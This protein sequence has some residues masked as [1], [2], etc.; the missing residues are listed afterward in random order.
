M[1]RRRDAGGGKAQDVQELPDSDKPVQP[2][3]HERSGEGLLPKQVEGDN[4]REGKPVEAH[5][6]LGVRPAQPGEHRAG[7]RPLIRRSSGMTIGLEHGFELGGGDRLAHEVALHLVTAEAA[8][9]GEL[10]GRL[11][12]FGH[13]LHAEAVGKADDGIDD[14]GAS[15]L[16]RWQD[17]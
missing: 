8:Q 12:P 13:R 4:R 3:Q 1:A 9:G 14:G 6:V 11:H 2:N 16:V 17:Q 10:L 5:L 15:R 7:G